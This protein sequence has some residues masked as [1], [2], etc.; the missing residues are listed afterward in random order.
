MSAITLLGQQIVE[1]HPIVKE[2]KLG[3]PAAIPLDSMITRKGPYRSGRSLRP[4]SLLP[5]RGG[6]QGLLRLRPAAQ[7]L[8]SDPAPPR[9]PHRRVHARPASS[10]ASERIHLQ[11]EYHRDNWTAR[12]RLNPADFYDL[13][14]PTKTSRKG[15]SVGLGYGRTFVYDLPRQADFSLKADYWGGLETLPDFQNVAVAVDT[16]LSTRAASTIATCGPPSATWT[17]RRGTRG[18]LVLAHDLVESQGYFRARAD[19]DLG[20]ALP[21]RHSSV[22]L[23]SSAGFSPGSPEQPYANFFFGG[24]GNNWVDHGNEKRYR[25]QHAFPGAEINEIGG[26][27]YVKSTLEWNLPPV[28]FRRVGSPGFYLT[29]ARPALFATGLVTNL[30]GAGGRRSLT[31]VGAQVDFQLTILSALDMT[32]SVGYA[33]AFED[34]S[35]PR[36]EAMVSLKVLK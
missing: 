5:D 4:E 12:F 21:I 18:T 24:F 16:L 8:G 20:V 9:E 2:W 27:N 32:L 29:W 1:K 15:Y 35:R 25:E 19:F 13:F 7:P 11:A 10:P 17:T 28:R 6:L 3:S 33:A 30:D 22:W 36:R 34:G 31:N 23:R 14:G 26:R